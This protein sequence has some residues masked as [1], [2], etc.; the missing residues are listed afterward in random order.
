VPG[1]TEIEDDCK[2][3]GDYG[4][5]LV[6]TTPPFIRTGSDCHRHTGPVMWGSSVYSYDN[7][8][9]SHTHTKRPVPNGMHVQGLKKYIGRVLCPSCRVSI[10]YQS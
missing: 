2:G 5:I 7:T 6:K 3:Q 9:H 10:S 1:R 8:P 4:L